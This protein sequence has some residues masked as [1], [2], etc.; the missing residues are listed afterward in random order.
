MSRGGVCAGQD[1]GVGGASVCV[2][3]CVSPADWACNL[4]VRVQ[5]QSRV[6][7][8]HRRH[9]T[10]RHALTQP[11]PLAHALQPFKLAGCWQ[12]GLRLHTERQWNTLARSCTH[13]THTLYTR[14]VRHR[15]MHTVYKPRPT[16]CILTQGSPSYISVARCLCVRVCVCVCACVLPSCPHASPARII[17]SATMPLLALSH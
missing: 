9:A 15:L 12:S 13:T 1:V 2:C 3:V 11:V 17:I 5:A 10:A 7:Q 4:Y 6:P 16:S 14:R 8:R